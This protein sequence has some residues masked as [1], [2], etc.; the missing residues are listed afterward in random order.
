LDEE[1]G[2]GYHATECRRILLKLLKLAPL[3]VDDI[4]HFIQRHFLDQVEKKDRR[5][6]TTIETSLSFLTTILWWTMFECDEITSL[7]SEK[8]THQLD[9]L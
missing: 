8:I 7:D 5:M 1:E 9:I 3:E 2:E 6:N 4:A